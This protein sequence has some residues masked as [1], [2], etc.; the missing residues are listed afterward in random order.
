[1]VRRAGLSVTT[2]K[3]STLYGYRRIDAEYYQPF[4]EENEA[5]ISQL[6]STRKLGEITTKFFKGI[7]DINADEY[8]ASGVPFVRINNLRNGIIDDSDIVFITP[9]RHRQEAKTALRRY[10]LALSKTAYPAASLVQIGACNVSQDI[11][12]V[13]TN[14]SEDFNFYL[15]AYLNTRF[16]LLQMKRLFQGNVQMHLSLPDAKTITIPIPNAAFQVKIRRIFEQSFLR[17][18]E[19]KH[20]YAQAQALFAAEL[21][22]DKLDLSESLY[23]VRRVSEVR[24]A[25]RADAEYF[26]P[27]YQRMMAMMGRSGQRIQDV[28]SLA[29]RRFRPQPGR[30][31]QYIE[32]GSLSGDGY[33][34]SE[35]V[36]GE[37]A[38]S[39]AQWIVKVG[40]VITSTVRPIRRLSALIEPE[41]D[42][43]VCSSGF[44]VLQPKDIEPELLLLYL[45]LP[46]VCEIL[47]LYTTASMYPA[48]STADLLNIPITLPESKT[49]RK[50]LIGKVRESRQARKDAQR[51]LAEAKAE[52]ERMIE[53]K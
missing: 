38:P 1:V 17:R 32:I 39:R 33:V 43:Y 18:E 10:D 44:A 2:V 16:G 7:F 42:G 50:E 8:V 3:V 20:S 29:N 4:Y 31:F 36:M 25:G 12:A 19:A 41:Q 23:S 51:L 5:L 40:D 53:G 13:R 15:A 46:I 24:E 37:D 34:E 27:K 21:G 52:V 48:I 28:A 11:I 35:T 9:E 45:R 6:P 14:L 30:P 49:L 22:L 26:Q 47:D